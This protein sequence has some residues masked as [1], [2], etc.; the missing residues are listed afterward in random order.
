MLET[1]Y[2]AFE[3]VSDGSYVFLCDM[4]YDFS[5]WAKP[6]V[7]LYGLPSEYMYG[8]GDLWEN[9]IHPDDRAAYHKGIDEI[10]SGNAAGHDMQYRAKSVTGEY[11]LCACR[12]IVIRDPSGEPNYFVGRI[13]RITPAL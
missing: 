6:A 3:A 9:R 11:D 5:R 10:F 8:A 1:L 13:T 7:E 12:G 4:K 2:K